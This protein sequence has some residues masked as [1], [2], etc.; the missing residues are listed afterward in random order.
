MPRYFIEV[1]YKGTAYSGF[2]SQKNA[3][4]IQAEVEKAF[5]VLQREAIPFVGSSRTDAGVHALQNFFHFDYH[6]K[7]NPQFVYKMN[8]ILPKNIV[9]KNLFEMSEDAHCRFD[10]ISRKYKYYI[11]RYKD[12]FLQEAAYYY[13]YQLNFEKLQQASYLVSEYFDFTSFSK[14]R[15]QVKSFNCRILES[16]WSM[17]DEQ[18]VY[19][20][21]ANRFLRGMVR[22]L[23]ATM[24]QVGREKISLEDFKNI[25][26]SK[27]ASRA[28]FAAPSHGLFLV[29]VEF[30][31][32][33]FQKG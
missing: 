30:P 17:Q 33:I 3:N 18:L 11:Y 28:S 10:A 22:A 16:C 27:D 32:G 15:T 4:T 8:S 7:P 5:A 9:V 14:K 31:A 13:P 6:S 24:L 29:K 1:S 26:E 19:S 21:K 20:V 23:V 2:Q 25:I 12:P